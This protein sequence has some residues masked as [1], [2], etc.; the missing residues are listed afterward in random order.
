MRAILQIRHP[1][2]YYAFLDFFKFYFLCML[3][4]FKINIILSLWSIATLKIIAL[5]L[6]GLFVSHIFLTPLEST[7]NVY[8]RNMKV[9]SAFAFIVYSYISL[10][11]SKRLI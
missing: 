10:I 5:L 2:S 8:T 1:F 6:F 4:N 7:Q 3:T 11:T 9:K